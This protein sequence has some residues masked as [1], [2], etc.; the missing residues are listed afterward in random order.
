M[1]SSGGNRGASSYFNKNGGPMGS[2][3]GQS[4]LPQ[5]GA[6]NN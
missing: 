5:V 6:S 4:G 1:V 3:G 2:P